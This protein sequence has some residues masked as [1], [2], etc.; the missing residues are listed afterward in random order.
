MA[1]QAANYLK[2]PLESLNLIT[3]HLG[4]GASM[5]AI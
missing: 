5:A 1:E 3:I 4:N 2:K